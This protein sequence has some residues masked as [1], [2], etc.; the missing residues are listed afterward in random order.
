VLTG[1]IVLPSQL[2]G[3]QL[4]TDLA[5]TT[6][7]IAALQISA[8]RVVDAYNAANGS[9]SELQ[10]QLANVDDTVS[11]QVDAVTATLDQAVPPPAPET[12]PADGSTTDQTQEADGAAA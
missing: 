11:A 3:I 1:N 9:L 12:L 8:Q 10:S 7:S 6:A 2:E 5:K 4:M